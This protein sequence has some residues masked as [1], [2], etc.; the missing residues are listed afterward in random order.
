MEQTTPTV[1]NNEQQQRFE[2]HVGDE[3]AFLEYRFHQN[4]IALMHTLVPESLGG[5]GLAAT[6]AKYALDWAREHKMPVIVYCPYVSAYLKRHPE[7]N[8]IVDKNYR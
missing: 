6:L 8:D 5:K 7:Y 4:E 2:I 3:V 1:V